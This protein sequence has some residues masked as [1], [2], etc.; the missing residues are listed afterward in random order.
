MSEAE[1]THKYMPHILYHGPSSK[2]GAYC[3]DSNRKSPFCTSKRAMACGVTSPVIRWVE[4]GMGMGLECSKPQRTSKSHMPYWWEFGMSEFCSM[5]IWITFPS[6][7]LI[8]CIQ[9]VE[10][11]NGKAYGSVMILVTSGVDEHI[12]NCL[13][14][15]LSSGSTIHS[16][17]LGSSVVENLEELSHHTG[18]YIWKYLYFRTFPFKLNIQSLLTWIFPTMKFTLW[19]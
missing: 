4:D 15:V 14:T 8:L 10:K 1:I 7:W 11:L 12:G 5:T 18:K 17:A 13:L 9:V 6:K 3:D 19:Q 16:I 2:L